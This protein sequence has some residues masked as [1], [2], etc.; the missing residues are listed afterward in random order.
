MTFF[1]GEKIDFIIWRKK[2]V[3]SFPN[4]HFFQILALCDRD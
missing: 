1:Q 4:L 2:C 3:Y